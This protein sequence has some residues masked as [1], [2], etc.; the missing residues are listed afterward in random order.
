MRILVFGIH[1][2]DVELGCGGSVA[3]AARQS[4]EITIVDLSS[5]ESSSNGTPQERAREALEAS[6]V[7]GVNERLNLGFPDTAIRSEDLSQTRAVVDCIRR[8]K[9]GILFLPDRRDPHPDHASGGLLLERAVYLSG[10]HG[11]ETGTDA[12]SVGAVLIYMGRTEFDP[13]FIVDI[14]STYSVKIQAI[15]AFRSQ[16]IAEEAR[17]PTPINSPDFLPFLEARSR[18][19]GHRIG[20]RYGEPLQTLK[21]TALREFSIFGN[22]QVPPVP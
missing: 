19:Y 3:L 21:P 20:A 15:R 2:D 5:G 10:V 11:F 22:S 4:H 13:H 8:I 6:K 1:P 7:L 17:R 14:T 12:W 16:F 9:P 18:L